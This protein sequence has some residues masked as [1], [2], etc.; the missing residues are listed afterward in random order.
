[1]STVTKFEQLKA[2][3]WNGSKKTQNIEMRIRDLRPR[4]DKS[5]QLILLLRLANKALEVAE[6]KCDKKEMKFQESVLENLMIQ[7]ENLIERI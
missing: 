6:R 7:A 1:M 5:S 2:Y 3:W 4:N